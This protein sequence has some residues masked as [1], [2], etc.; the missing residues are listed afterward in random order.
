MR[1][2]KLVQAYYGILRPN[3][4]LSGIGRAVTLRDGVTSTRVLF[5]CII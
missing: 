4:L 1:R 2:V 5:V 3:V